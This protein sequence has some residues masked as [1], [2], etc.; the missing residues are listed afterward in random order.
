MTYGTSG[1]ELIFKRWLAR[2]GIPF[3]KEGCSLDTGGARRQ[4]TPDFYLT[5]LNVFIEVKPRNA[6]EETVYI[7]K[8]VEMNSPRMKN[9]SFFAVAFPGNAKDPSSFKAFTVDT[10]WVRDA[11]AANKLFYQILGLRSSSH[12]V[13]TNK[14][15]EPGR[16]RYKKPGKDILDGFFK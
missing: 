16:Q 6:A 1:Q 9:F 7:E 5:T 10:G 8:A 11:A 15:S 12:P 4:Y 13:K 3:L 14:P 2:K